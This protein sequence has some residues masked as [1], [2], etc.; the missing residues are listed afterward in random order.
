[1]C[2]QAFGSCAQHFAAFSI[3]KQHVGARHVAQMVLE[4]EDLPGD[5][6][7]KI[8]ECCCRSEFQTTGC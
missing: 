1:M 5:I 3:S 7:R 6:K 4:F 2:M 8:F